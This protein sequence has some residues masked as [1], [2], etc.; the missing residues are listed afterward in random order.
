MPHPL[1]A[2]LLDIASASKCHFQVPGELLTQRSIAAMQNCTCAALQSIAEP[3]QKL[4]LVMRH[5]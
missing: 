3:P 1:A 4:K 5:P 2:H